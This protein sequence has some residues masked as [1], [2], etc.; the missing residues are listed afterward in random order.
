MRSRTG[1]RGTAA[2]GASPVRTS[3]HVTTG[4]TRAPNPSSAPSARAP[5][6]DPTTWPC[7]WRDTRTSSVFRRGDKKHTKKKKKKKRK[8]THKHCLDTHKALTLQ[9]L[10]CYKLPDAERLSLT[11]Q[12]LLA[13]LSCARKRY[14]GL[15]HVLLLTQ[16][17][18]LRRL[19]NRTSKGPGEAAGPLASRY[20]W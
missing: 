11:T 15:T 3:W 17:G 9:Q 7:T 10:H 5:S 4:S 8:E 13:L 12:L 6:P 1:A 19:Y 16:S 20:T 2:T 18:T 14:D